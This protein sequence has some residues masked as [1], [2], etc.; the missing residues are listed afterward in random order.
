M[1]A[2]EAYNRLR[3]ILLNNTQLAEADRKAIC[4]AINTLKRQT[5]CMAINTLNMQIS[6]KPVSYMM[7]GKYGTIIGLCP[8]CGAGNNSEYPYCGEC[9]QALEWEK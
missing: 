6:I 2:A 7:F 5:I 3:D 9:G 1:T 8:T 4:M